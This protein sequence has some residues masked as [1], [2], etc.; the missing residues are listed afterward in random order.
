MKNRKI[1]IILIIVFLILFGIGQIVP[2]I[3]RE[4]NY[5]EFSLPAQDSSDILYNESSY[6]DL[7]DITQTLSKEGESFAYEINEYIYSSDLKS[8][9]YVVGE[10]IKNNDELYSGFYLDYVGKIIEIKEVDSNIIVK[11]LNLDLLK[12]SLFITQIELDQIFIGQSANLYYNDQKF[13]GSVFSIGEEILS[14]K[15]AVEISIDEVED[16]SN[17]KPGSMVTVSLNIRE[18]KSVLRISKYLVYYIG[19]ASYVD[20]VVFFNGKESLVQ[21]KIVTGIEGDDFFEVI[22]GIQKNDKV[23]KSLGR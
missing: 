21:T 15:I 16:T 10:Y 12:I 8:S 13:T 2:L 20:K 6:V 11:V 14:G 4:N 17:M 5:D 18:K 22:N 19:K 1:Y 3:Q 9:E 7:G 23:A